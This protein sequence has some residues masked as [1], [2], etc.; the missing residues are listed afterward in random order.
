M[1]ADTVHLQYD[2]VLNVFLIVVGVCFKEERIVL[3]FWR[4]LME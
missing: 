4:A 3:R 1:T 2:V